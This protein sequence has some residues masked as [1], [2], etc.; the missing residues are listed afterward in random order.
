MRVVLFGSS[1]FTESTLYAI[2][3]S[4]HQLISVVTSSNKPSGR[5]KTKTLGYPVLQP[6]DLND[7]MFLQ[8]LRD[9]YPDIFVVVAFRKIPDSVLQIPKTFSINLH[10]SLLPK[11]RGATP[12]QRAIIEGDKITGISIIK[13]S[14][15][16]DSGNILFQKKIKINKNENAGNLSERLAIAG[17]EN[18]VDVINKIEKDKF[19]KG[20]SQNENKA[21]YASKFNSDY[22]KINWDLKA[23]TIHNKIRALSPQPGAYCLLKYMSPI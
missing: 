3:K 5:G 20:Y 6:N 4:E 8:N 11:Y 21:T 19:L 23:A 7:E 10:P 12:I 2:D 13:L 18:I 16:I 17:A 14:S 15:K 1:K 22:F 9:C